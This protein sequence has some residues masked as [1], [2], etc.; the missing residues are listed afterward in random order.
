[1][2]L[3]IYSEILFMFSWI[4][5]PNHCFLNWLLLDQISLFLLYCIKTYVVEL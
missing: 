1:M 2:L 4:I 5:F 3:K